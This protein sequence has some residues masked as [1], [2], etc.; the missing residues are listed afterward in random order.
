MTDK[1]KFISYD[2]RYPNLC[3]G[4]LTIEINGKMYS[5]GFEL[6]SGGGVTFDEDWSEIVTDGE[7][8]VSV[9]PELE[10]YKE[11]ITDIV[12]ENVPQ[13]CCGGCV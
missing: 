3:S 13:G 9:P 4:R 12:N 1:I 11:Q 8:S 2:G 6:R 7:W 10:K 5:D